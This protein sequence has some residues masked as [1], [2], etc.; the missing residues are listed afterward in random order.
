MGYASLKNQLDRASKIKHAMA[1]LESAFGDEEFT[2]KQATAELAGSGVS[3]DAIL[4]HSGAAKTREEVFAVAVDDYEFEGD[5]WR[6]VLPDGSKSYWGSELMA[7][8]FAKKS[9]CISC[10]KRAAGT[11]THDVEAK[12]YYY[13]LTFDKLKL[14]NCRDLEREKSLALAKLNAQVADLKKQIALLESL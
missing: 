7:T 8:S 11:D 9:G 1:V 2:R 5:Y 12:R 10:E 13:T 14:F 3:F 6:C 4:K